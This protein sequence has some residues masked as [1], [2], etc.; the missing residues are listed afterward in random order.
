MRRQPRGELTD[1]QADE[2]DRDEQIAADIARDFIG[3]GVDAV[4]L[5][6]WMGDLHKV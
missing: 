5:E 1:N 6:R 4:E 2:E 3:G